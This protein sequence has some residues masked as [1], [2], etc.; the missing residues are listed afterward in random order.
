MAMPD[1]PDPK[2]D[3]TPKLDTQMVELLG[4]SRLID[5]LLRAGLEV[6][7]PER[8]RGV[9]LIAYADLSEQVDRFSARPIQLKVA[10]DRRLSIDR[11]YERISNLIIAFVWHIDDPN[12]TEIYAMTYGQVLDLAEQAGWTKTKSWSTGSYSSRHPGKQT[13]QLMQRHRMTPQKW[14]ELIVGDASRDP[15]RDA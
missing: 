9:D 7:L 6:A 5:Q 4:R 8:D 3:D 13:M 15:R 1:S 14:R 11:K 12:E 10:T 2:H